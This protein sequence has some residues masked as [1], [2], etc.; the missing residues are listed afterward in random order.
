MVIGK[1][2]GYLKGV[3][4]VI[5]NRNMIEMAFFVDLLIVN[6]EVVVIFYFITW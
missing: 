2:L 1:V 5:L 6:I 3:L 4:I